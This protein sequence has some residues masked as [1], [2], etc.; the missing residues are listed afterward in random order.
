MD[1]RDKWWA[2]LFWPLVS[3]LC[4]PDDTSAFAN[5]DPTSVWLWRDSECWIAAGLINLGKYLVCGN[6]RSKINGKQDGVLERLPA[7]CCPPATLEWSF[8]RPE[9]FKGQQMSIYIC[10]LF[11]LNP[12]KLPVCNFLKSSKTSIC[13]RACVCLCVHKPPGCCFWHPGWSFPMF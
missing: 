2:L 1:H 9:V 7:D 8:N 6:R 5:A 11:L 4:T 3:Y 12:F 10:K 13:V